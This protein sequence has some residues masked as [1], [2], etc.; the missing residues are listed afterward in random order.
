MSTSVIELN[1]SEIRVGTG[2][3]IVWR[4]PG[5][6]FITDNNIEIGE[7]AASK[8][9]LHPRAANNRYWKNLNQDPLP[10]SSPRAS[11]RPGPNAIGLSKKSSTSCGS[12]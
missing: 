8:A 4:S 3:R 2:G 5:Y 11:S 12:P 9:R 1:D 10:S 6:S 7:A